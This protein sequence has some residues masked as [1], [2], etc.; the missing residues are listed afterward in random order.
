MKTLAAAIVIFVGIFAVGLFAGYKF[1]YNRPTQPQ[2][3]SSVDEAGVRQIVM[4]FGK[5][6]QTV[7]LSGSQD[8][9]EKAMQE[10]Y[11][12]FVAPELLG[13]WKLHPSQIPGRFTSSPW[14]DRVEIQNVKK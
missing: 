6:L 5:K 1:G 9:V 3:Q 2:N 10:N 8:V 4:A 7:P 12:D 13:S 11:D 14:P